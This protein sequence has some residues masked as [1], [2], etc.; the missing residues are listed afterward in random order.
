MTLAQYILATDRFSLRENNLYDYYNPAVLRAI[1]IV[2]EGSITK[3]K[4]GSCMRRNGGRTYW[5]NNTFKFWNK[6]SK[7]VPYIYSKSKKSCEKS[8]NI[9][10]ERNK[11]IS[12]KL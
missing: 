2:A 12:F 1:N 8:K 7:Y 10:S 5:D 11:K 6:K 3:R 4:R 9:T